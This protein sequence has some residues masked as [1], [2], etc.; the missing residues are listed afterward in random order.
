VRLIG[1]IDTTLREPLLVFFDDKIADGIDF[2]IIDLSEAHYIS[3]AIWG[4][5]IT[6]LKHLRERGGDIIM[7]SPKGQVLKIYKVMAFDKVFKTFNSVSEALRYVKGE[8]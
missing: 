6:I 3:S 2:F 7:C 8:G 5:F 1:E 4:A